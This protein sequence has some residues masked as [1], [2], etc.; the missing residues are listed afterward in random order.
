MIHH[1]YDNYMNHAYPGDELMPLSCSGRVRGSTSSRGDIDD[2]LGNFALTLVDSLDTLAVIGDID[3][4]EKAVH[5]V[6]T[7]VKFDSNLVVSVFETNIRILGGLIGGHVMSKLMKHENV[8]MQ[9][10]KDELLYMAIDIANRLLPAFN[11]TTGVPHSRVNLKYGFH[12]PKAAVRD[13]GTTCTACAG[14]FLVEFGALSRLMGDSVY[15]NKAR[16]AV[17][18]IWSKRSMTSDLVGTI[19]NIKTGEWIKKTSGL[20]AGI[21]SY[22]EYI[23]KAYVLLGDTSF[24]DRFN[25]HYKA[26]KKYIHDGPL[27][28]NVNMQKPDIISRSHVDALSAFWPAIQVMKGDLKSAIGVHEIFYQ[29]VK[30]HKFL[31][32]AF[33]SDF[34]LVWNHHPIRPE[35]VESTYFLYRATGDSHYLDV[36]EYMIQAIQNFTRV[37]CGFAAISNV[38]TGVKEDRFD[39]FVLAETF[40][41][42]Y[43]IFTDDDQL[44]F[45]VDDFIFTTEAH[46]VPMNWKAPYL[47]N[48]STS[49]FQK[50]HNSRSSGPVLPGARVENEEISL[51]N[52]CHNYNF[53]NNPFY[54]FNVRKSF[55]GFVGRDKTLTNID[56]M[57][58]QPQVIQANTK[59]HQLNFRPTSMPKVQIIKSDN[60]KPTPIDFVPLAARDFDSTKSAHYETLRMMGIEVMADTDGNLQLRHTYQNAYNPSLAQL[61][62]NF[63]AEAWKINEEAKTGPKEAIVQILSAPYH[64]SMFFKVGSALFGYNLAE[65]KEIASYVMIAKPFDACSIADGHNVE[66]YIVL[67]LRGNCLF[68]EKARTVEEKGGI[69]LIVIDSVESTSVLTHELFTMSADTN[70]DPINIPAVFVLQKEGL[71]LLALLI[72]EGP[73]YVRLAIQAE[74]YQVLSQFYEL[75]GSFDTFTDLQ[76]LHLYAQSA[77]GDDLA[78]QHFEASAEVVQSIKAPAGSDILD[79]KADVLEP[80]VTSDVDNDPSIS[81]YPAGIE[82]PLE[83]DE[84]NENEEKSAGTRKS[85]ILVK[86]YIPGEIPMTGSSME[87]DPSLTPVPFAVAKSLITKHIIIEGENVPTEQEMSESN[88]K[89]PLA[90]VF[91]SQIPTLGMK[92]TW[93]SISGS[94]AVTLLDHIQREHKTIVRSFRNQKFTKIKIDRMDNGVAR[95]TGIANLD[96]KNESSDQTL[97]Y[98]QDKVLAELMGEIVES[99]NVD[100]FT[101]KV[102]VN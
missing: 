56:P 5:K 50:S 7:E 86:P 80:S 10:Y 77:L 89:D 102:T 90:A 83:D 53:M 14:T 71:A 87:N 27:L 60:M 48:N 93:F 37:P 55:S 18:Y 39:S 51:D 58:I 76:Q 66:G 32:E 21:D 100:I 91:Y 2:S 101:S 73:L 24:L 23:F 57:C 54:A 64:G 74:Y 36:A 28:L 61:G 4:F 40:K 59:T 42:L 31:P 12:H 96:P 26:I 68:A 6:I 30:L 75:D 22:Y 63:I 98:D 62:L 29:V 70:P 41:Y 44:W 88:L 99:V 79:E 94:S 19:M 25:K 8:G 34:K 81:Q 43:L 46:L 11:T 67:A 92:V 33:N 1:A 15:E 20:G 49:R 13:D 65:E 69:G 17:D 85:A 95:L 52:T 72:N 97:N 38:K 82:T 35:F 47:A 45:N 84:D 16:E 9:W 3:R 78:V